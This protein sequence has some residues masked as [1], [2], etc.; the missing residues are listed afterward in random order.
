MN[1]ILKGGI[2]SL[3]PNK[4][5]KDAEAAL[6]EAEEQEVTEQGAE[7]EG[8]EG[9]EYG[10]SQE[11][12][13]SSSKKVK[14][15]VEDKQTVGERDEGAVEEGTGVDSVG[16]EPMPSEE[17][18]VAP[19]KPLV[20]PLEIDGE[21]VDDG[22]KLAEKKSKEKARANRQDV[23]ESGGS[24]G[25]TKTTEPKGDIWDRHEDEVHHVEVNEIDINPSQPR[26]KF[27]PMEM[28]ELTRS[29]EQHGILQPLVVR[30]TEDGYELVAGERRLRAAKELQWDRVPCV[31]R[32]GVGSDAARLELA[33]IENIQREDLNPVEEAMAYRQLNEEY[34]MTHEEI[35]VR[36]GRSRVGVTNTIRVLQLPPEI[37]KGM[38]DGK[39]T[40]G[41][42]RA[43]LM[44]PD[45][46]KQ[47]RF[48][49][50]LVEEGLTVRK[51]ET[52]AR[53][54]QRA[55]EIDDPM[56][57]KRR[58]RSA[59]EA[60]QS[61]LLEDRYGYDARVYFDEIKNRYEVNFKCHSNEELRELM[62]RLLGEVGLL[63]EDKI[64]E[65]VIED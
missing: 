37:Q 51:A 52:R 5:T 23:S 2:F 64:D 50:H 34:G 19:S 1:K 27:D 4:G 46:Q 54:I 48:Y 60:K 33:L 42:A 47:V 62:G 32:R 29:V 3:I 38:V 36:V 8:V 58:G 12:R 49:R 15:V 43:I 18:V 25:E 11:E 10:G 17:E 16:E 41:H 53:R 55:M 61:A 30:R 57:R 40:G 26:R 6:D 28:E 63:D 59:F 22:G 39:I 56:R 44:I 65:D 45:E 21:G 24:S 13:T 35:G 14:V 31:I 9:A 20:T 7:E